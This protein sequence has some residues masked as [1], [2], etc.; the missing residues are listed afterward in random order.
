MTSLDGKVAV[1]T[2]SGNG[3]GRAIALA[4]AGEGARVVVSDILDEDGERTVQEITDLDGSAVF[5]KADV[6]NV[7]QAQN[8]IESASTIFGVLG[9]FPTEVVCVA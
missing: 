7:E 5:V 3:I 6:S 9:V 8:L 1:V 2:G 4:M